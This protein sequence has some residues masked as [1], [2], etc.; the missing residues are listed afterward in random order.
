[1]TENDTGYIKTLIKDRV[2]NGPVLELGAGYGG[3]TCRELITDA[4]LDYYATDIAASEGVTYV[5]DFSNPEN[6]AEV[7]GNN[8]FECVLVLNLLEHT[9][10]PI[11]ILDCALGLVRPGGKLIVIAPAVWTLHNYPI[12][13]YRLLPN[14]YEQYAATRGCDLLPQYFEFV[15]CGRISNFIDQDGNYQ[16]PSP[17]T[18]SKF[19]YWWSRI[20]QKIFNTYGRG[21]AFPSHVAIGAVYSK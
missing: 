17:T 19:R 5:A 13:C 4:R 10:D 14:W 1:M 20:I 7:F 18:N 16:L 9:F 3:A 2:L 15:G 12:D 11:R 6:I 21:M 8:Q